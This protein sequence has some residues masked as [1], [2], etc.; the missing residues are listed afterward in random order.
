MHV[1]QFLQVLFHETIFVSP[2]LLLL[3]TLLPQ[4]FQ[5]LFVATGCDYI[6]FFSGIGKATAKFITS[7][8][9]NIPSTLAEVCIEN[10]NYEQGFL[11]FLRLLGVVLPVL[12]SL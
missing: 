1:P 11:S 12:S 10:N 6:S 3:S 7:G 8:Q 2:Q 5:T 9:E 4:I